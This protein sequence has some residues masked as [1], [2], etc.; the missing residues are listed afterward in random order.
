M[1]SGDAS[2]KRLGRYEPGKRPPTRRHCCGFHDEDLGCGVSFLGLLLLPRIAVE[3]AEKCFA[4]VRG[5][6]SQM[7]D[8]GFDLLTR[9]ISQGC[10]SA[11]ISGV[12]LHQT[13]VEPMLADQKAET[14]AQTRLTV[15]MA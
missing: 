14:V 2:G 5:S 15:A 10:G 1:V 9:C 3:V 6:F 12:S 13:G 4:I 7:V 8:E 11:V